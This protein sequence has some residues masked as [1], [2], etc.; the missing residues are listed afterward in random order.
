M[1]KAIQKRLA[2]MRSNPKSVSFSDALAIAGHYFGEPRISNS[3]HHVFK[4]PW[5]A[6][7]R[8][9]LQKAK[10][11]GAKPYQVRQLLAAIDKLTALKAGVLTF[12]HAAKCLP[13]RQAPRE[14]RHWPEARSAMMVGAHGGVRREEQGMDQEQLV[15]RI[16]GNPP[17]F[18]TG[19]IM[20]RAR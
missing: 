18:S 9:N 2:D 19:R 10:S 7:P 16:G 11:G 3:S 20:A 6:D 12:G 5:P 4:T 13:E 15:D 1:A 8:V 14:T 17:P